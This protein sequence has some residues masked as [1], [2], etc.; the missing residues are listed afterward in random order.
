LNKVPICLVGCG[1]MGS[2]HVQG[3]AA[4]ARTGMSNVELVAVCDVREDNALRVAG[5]A[6]AAL[7]VRPRIHRSI[8]DAIADPSIVAFDVVTEAFS[9]LS[10]VLPALEAG[11]HVLCEKPHEQTVRS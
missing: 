8:A 11:R 4:L 7:G 2:R 9:H 1:G 10:V 5:E 3:F 6:E